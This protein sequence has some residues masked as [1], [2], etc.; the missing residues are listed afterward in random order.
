MIQFIIEQLGN[1][2]IHKEKEKY[3]EVIL[4]YHSKT[5]SQIH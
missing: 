1:M 3:E 2:E 4:Y 5:M